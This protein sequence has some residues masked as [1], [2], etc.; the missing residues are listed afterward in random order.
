MDATL[1]AH[2]YNNQKQRYQL[3]ESGAHN[4]VKIPVMLLSL[5]QYLI[6]FTLEINTITMT[7]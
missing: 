4:I 3:I 6:L 5:Y 2:V 7:P 1:T